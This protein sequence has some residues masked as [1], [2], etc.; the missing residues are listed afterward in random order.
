MKPK[1]YPHVDPKLYGGLYLEFLNK[2]DILFMKN[3][4]DSG[5]N[6]KISK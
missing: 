4:K 5:Q 6:I 3:L 2:K 1:V